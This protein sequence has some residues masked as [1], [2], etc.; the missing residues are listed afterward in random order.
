MKL[1]STRPFR[2]ILVI[3][4]AGA[5]IPLWTACTSSTEVAGGGTRG[6]NP[7]V[8]ILVNP[9]QTPCADA[10]VRLVPS[11][12][13]PV[14]DLPLSKSLIDTTN[15][16]GMFEVTADTG[17]YNLL[18]SRVL[19]K[20]ALLARNIHVVGDTVRLSSQSMSK[21]GAISITLPDSVDT[22]NGYVFINGTDIYE[23]ITSKGSMI[24][25]SVPSGVMPS[26]RYATGNGIPVSAIFADSV[27]V[28]AG[29]T[30]LVQAGTWTY[31]RN[32]VLN[33]TVSG[34]NVNG[35]VNGFPV[36][37]RLNSNNFNFSQAKA[38][39]ADI[40]FAKADNSRLAYE[41]ERWDSA[42]GAAE[43]WVKV[44]TVYGNDS[45]H[46]IT[47]YWGNINATSESNGKVVFDTASGFQ[48]VWHLDE[49]TGAPAA[50]ATSNHYDG[51]P[52]L[53]PPVAVPGMICSAQAFN[54]SSTSIDVSNTA[55]SALTFPQL[56]TYTVSA[57]VYLDSLPSG[58]TAA[59]QFGDI[60][61]KGNQEY[62]L[63][64][65]LSEW[66][67]S[68]METGL[69]WDDT[70][71]RAQVGAWFH[72]VGVRNGSKQYLY[73]NGAVAD[74]SIMVAP[75][76]SSQTF[77]QNLSLGGL[78]STSRYFLGG[79]ID[80]ARILNISQSANWIKLC[81]MNQK[82]NDA[83]IVFK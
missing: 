5:L 36:L 53:A 55:N 83:L 17:T 4:S 38:N 67:F 29:E 57:W 32:L 72:V 56:G 79:K 81:Y 28:F 77:P 47:M 44:D 69:G 24:L 76:T 82:A 23:K 45:S 62:H 75:D 10:L 66:Q 31:H 58:T 27:Q 51:T 11:S 25:S 33:T 43:V 15:E 80:E 46:V 49:S 26:I 65:T 18:A 71:V 63:Q 78:P 37:V 40:R 41:I 7:V 54:G 22:I 12:Y 9:D 1:L 74:S 39:G 20:S 13:N 68:E 70:Q 48:G 50:D 6:G 30:T 59:N 73:L 35:N 3:C 21:V 2:Q 34:A 19:D 60:I 42:N 64:V 16:A 14:T 61:A 52:S 8:G